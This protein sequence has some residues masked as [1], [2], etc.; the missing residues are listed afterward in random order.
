MPGDVPLVFFEILG[1]LRAWRE[2][3]ELDL[4][5]GKQ[6]AVLAVLL[7]NANRPTPTTRIVDAVWG[8]GPPENGVNVVQKYVAGLRRILEPGR[9]PRSPGQLL[10]WTEAGY[11]LH[12][13][14]GSLDADVFRDHLVRARAAADRADATRYIRSALALWRGDALAGLR[15]AY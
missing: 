1:P 14:P 2:H 4:G 3:T 5:P 13:P 12:V 6:R 10:T 7:L 15:G 11:T 8:D 9:S